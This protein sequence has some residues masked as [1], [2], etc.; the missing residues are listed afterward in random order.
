MRRSSE[1][2]I[3]KSYEYR[4]L[5]DS[6]GFKYWNWELRQ[7]W[8]GLWVCK[9]D[10]ENRHES[11]FYRTRNDTHKLPFYRADTPADPT[12]SWTPVV[13]GLT[14]NNLD[15]ET[16]AFDT[17]YYYV[18]TT[19]SKTRAIVT[20]TFNKPTASDATISLPVRVPISTTTVAAGTLTLPTTPG[21]AGT[22]TILN[23][24]GE[25]IGTATVAAGNAT[26]TLPSW[27]KKRGNL[28]FSATYGT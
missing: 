21:S 13:A 15:A 8:D 23:S 20:A 7:R 11:D 19:Q 2:R 28:E 18:D 17:G 16:G 26:V 1:N 10:W 5:C 4:V 25:L 6:C 3:G 14:F 22:M 24:N 27:T 9:W 12:S